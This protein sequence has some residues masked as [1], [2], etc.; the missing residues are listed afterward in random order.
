[1]SN[2]RKVETTIPSGHTEFIPL[3]V[4]P[5]FATGLLE[6]DEVPRRAAFAYRS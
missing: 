4:T 1:M 3:L 5:G 6:D 2:S